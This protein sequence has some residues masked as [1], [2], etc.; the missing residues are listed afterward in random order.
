MPVVIPAVIAHTHAHTHAR[1]RTRTHTHAHTHT[2]THTDTHTHT[3]IDHFH[4]SKSIDYFFKL[5]LHNCTV[6]IC[7]KAGLIYTQGLKYSLGS[8]AY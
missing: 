7:I 5:W 3:P 2:H 1:T 6:L 4:I 8:A